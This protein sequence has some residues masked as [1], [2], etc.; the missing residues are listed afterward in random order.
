MEGKINKY[1]CGWLL[2][3]GG[4]NI[5]NEENWKSLR[6]FWAYFKRFVFF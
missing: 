3:L 2:G 6:V 1:T 4:W 5:K